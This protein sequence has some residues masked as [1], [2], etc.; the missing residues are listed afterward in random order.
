MKSS[1]W[2]RNATWNDA[3]AAQFEQKLARARRKEQ[4]LRIQACI[5]AHSRPDV[6]HSL[7][8]R[9]FQ[10]P[11]DFDHAQAHVDRANAYLSEDRLEEAL[12]SYEAALRREAAFPKLLTQAYLDVPFLI[13]WRGLAERFG[14]ALELLEA[15]RG[16]LL[17]PV[18]HFRWHAAHALIASGGDPAATRMHAAAAMDAAKRDESGFKNHP[19]V[20]LVRGSLA[21]IVSKMRRL[22]DV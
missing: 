17:F 20:G 1:E 2:F 18:D 9:Y 15:G 3:V 8:D 6:A 11:D 22:S 21:Q 16:R 12:D 7:L 4:Y 13:A 5:L 10:L 19:T 14:R